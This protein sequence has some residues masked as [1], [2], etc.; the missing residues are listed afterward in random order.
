[1]PLPSGKQWQKMQVK[2]VKAQFNKEQPAE[3]VAVDGTVFQMKYCAIY[4]LPV[5][6]AQILIDNGFAIKE[7]NCPADFL[8]SY[9][10]VPPRNLITEQKRKY[11]KPK[12]W[13]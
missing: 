10:E 9:L 1:M 3:A 2:I 5:E 6:T 13:K 11:E 7:I 4:E 12:E 8:V